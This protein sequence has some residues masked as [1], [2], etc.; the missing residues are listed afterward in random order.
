M[1]DFL[2]YRSISMA[3]V[4]QSVNIVW[5]FDDS[6]SAEIIDNLTFLV[7]ATNFKLLIISTTEATGDDSDIFEEIVEIDE[8][9]EIKLVPA[10]SPPAV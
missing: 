5:N 2:R 7:R 8:N 3:S 4:R 9:R 1:A 10:A 6:P